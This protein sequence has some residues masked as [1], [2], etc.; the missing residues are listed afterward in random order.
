MTFRCIVLFQVVFFVAPTCLLWR[1]TGAH[2]QESR[3]VKTPVPAPA[4]MTKEASP[5]QESG[6]AQKSASSDS[7][8]QI[9][10]AEAQASLIQNTFVA[11]PIDGVVSDVFV[12]AGDRVGKDDD[13][14]RFD[15]EHA[16]TEYEATRAAYD[17]A[18]LTGESDV[19]ERYARRTLEMQEQELERSR[20]ANESYAGT[21]SL[22]EV[23]Q[24]RL[25]ADQAQLSIEKAIHER[26]IA[27]AKAREKLAATKMAE[28][29]LK[30][31]H[32]KSAVSGIVAEVAV[33]PGEWTDAGKPIVR[34]ISLD[35]IR[36][37]CFIDGR[38]HGE[39]LIGSTIE[40]YAKASDGS[41]RSPLMG[42]VTYVSP[43][44]HPVTGQ[45]RLWATVS[46]PDH[47][48]RAGMFGR[49]VIFPAKK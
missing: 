19:D 25:V 10:V 44:L 40:F 14:V 2:A 21:I 27:Q 13:L 22:S 36:V 39:E 32:V 6:L 29:R 45:S 46:N 18:K 7:R 24:L 38:M 35:P 17:A 5:S 42:T 31:H 3:P 16:E 20:I 23:A 30:R 34:V 15:A 47:R 33:E 48:V 49:L 43:E 8:N 9:A 4:K 11:A 28:V 26:A 12:E 37:E 1:G 41:E